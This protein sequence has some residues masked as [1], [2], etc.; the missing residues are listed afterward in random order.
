MAAIFL[1]GCAG[2][3]RASG[4]A[5]RVEVDSLYV[6]AEISLEA[7]REDDA[8]RQLLEAAEISSD[9]GLAE[10][11]ARL[12]EESGL[13]EA[14]LRAVARWAELTPDD[15]RSTWFR[16]IFNLR[17]GRLDAAA[18]DFGTVIDALPPVS[19]GSGLA[20]AFDVLASEP[21]SAAGT[22]VM[23]NLVE[24][25]PGH[26][27]GHYAL[28]RLALRSGDFELCLEN[29]REAARLE[30]EWLDAQLLLARGLLVGGNTQAS[31]EL[32]R[33]VAGAN[34]QPAVRQQLAELLLWAGEQD[35]A[36]SILVD[37]VTNN[38]E[39]VDARRALAFLHLARN[40]LEQA[41]E[42]FENLRTRDAYSTEAFY[43]L[44]RIAEGQGNQLQATRSYAR[45]TEGT[46]VV[47]A[48]LRIARIMFE[49]TG[50]EAAALEHLREFG[51]ENTIFASDMIVARSEILMQLGR[52]DAA[53]ELVTDA[54]EQAPSDTSL[55][56]AHVQLFT[57]MSQEAGRQGNLDQAEQIL[58]D[59]LE[60][61][62]GNITLRYSLSLLYGNQGRNRRAAAELEELVDD[63]PDNPA[64]L[65]AYGYL[66]T[67][68]FDRHAEARD[69]IARALAM[70]PDNP[71]IIDS[72]GWVLFKQG[73]FE[74]ALDYLA[75]AYRLYN[76][77][78]VIAHLIDTHMALGND[79]AAREL[80]ETGLDEFPD[81]R[82]LLEIQQRLFQ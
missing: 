48:Q 78:E 80:F 18:R 44:G 4:D 53:L 25:R 75:R 57:A 24:E 71:A 56:L 68:E 29:A 51:N 1:T 7:G 38:P 69:Y 55:Q 15:D 13:T 36:E 20:L 33:E 59:A 11:A 12:A 62:P 16:G 70:D 74:A 73:E 81:S 8:T 27:E 39:I 9:P 14:G 22:Y 17:S 42:Q 77:P 63:E 58:D 10:R 34:P 61:Y 47:E 60:L 66:L 49:Q 5:S 43:Y 54:L 35:E 50:D 3:P 6:L 82:H 26:A 76:D 45:V 30:P 28:A 65:N 41:R 40:E 2:M 32:A 52:T 21:T 37:I 79:A 64:L 31:I 72:M 23:R 46:H 67:D 19:T